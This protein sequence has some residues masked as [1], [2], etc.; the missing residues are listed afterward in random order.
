[1][2]WEKELEADAKGLEYWRKLGWDSRIWVGILRGFESYT[3]RGTFFIQPNC[4]LSKHGERALAK[5]EKAC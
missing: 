1:M 2:P 4:A 5:K 3:I